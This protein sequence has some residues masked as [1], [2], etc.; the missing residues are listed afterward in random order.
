MGATQSGRCPALLFETLAMPMIVGVVLVSKLPRLDRVFDY[1]VPDELAEDIRFGIAVRVRVGKSKGTSYGFIVEIKS[2]S[3]HLGKLSP[4]EEI[5][6]KEPILT[7]QILQL[8]RDL[9]RRNVATVGEYLKLAIPAVMPTVA[10]TLTLQK[11]QQ[12]TA[13]PGEREVILAS[14]GQ[15][16]II[17]SSA[18]LYPFW[19][20]LLLDKLLDLEQTQSVIVLVPDFRRQQLLLSAIHEVG[21]SDRVRDLTGSG[22]KGEHFRQWML[23]LSG[24]IVIGARSAVFAP[25]EQ[26]QIIVVD[27]ADDSYY[28]QAAP[29]LSVLEAVLIRQQLSNC[30]LC[31]ISVSRSIETQRL[32]DLGYLQDKSLTAIKPKISFSE[33]T[34]RVDPAAFSAIRNGLLSGPV[35]V[36]VASPG[37]SV[38]LYCKDC[39]AIARC[40]NCTG[41]LL[42]D[43]A[44]RLRCR[45]C[46]GF[47]GSGS[48]DCGTG[49]FTT[50]RAGATRTAS[51]IGKAFPGVRVI[52][53]TKQQ[54]LAQVENVPAIVVATAAA[55]PYVISGYSAVV[56]LDGSVALRRQSLRARE[57]AFHQW[58]NAVA[59]AANHAQVVL[60]GVSGSIARDFALWDQLGFAKRELATRMKPLMPPFVRFGSISGPFPQVQQ[61]CDRLSDFEGLEILGPVP[62]DTDARAILRYPISATVELAS[63]I[64]AA[65]GEVGSSS[66]VS[67]RGKRVRSLKVRMLDSEVI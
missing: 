20:K 6:S 45:W 17:G 41:P 67:E 8:C 5:V 60:A 16:S 51:E 65:L 24:G 54:R 34:A 57:Q 31:L 40:L 37:D 30:S 22:T 23:S 50:G 28:D 2:E 27:E 10:K 9:A 3:E 61:L 13:E 53:S 36:Q 25:V 11:T 42:M 47:Q 48:C 39:E 46:N 66:R 32:V 63:A 55:E 49:N 1:L 26:S 15:T 19:V 12:T 38:A 21:L 33:S 29:Y 43:G 64:K 4:I 56:L 59:L 58:S 14:V 35:L 18:Q 62:L 52:E 44:K 7:N